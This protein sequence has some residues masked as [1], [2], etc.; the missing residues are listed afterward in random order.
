VLQLTKVHPA[1]TITVYLLRVNRA[2]SLPGP[3]FVLNSPPGGSQKMLR[4][5]LLAT[6]FMG[7]AKGIIPA[8]CVPAEWFP[9]TETF[10]AIADIQ[11]QGPAGSELHLEEQG[12]RVAATLRDY[13][14]KAIPVVTK[15]QGSIEE[16]NPVGGGPTTCK[17]RLSGKDNRGPVEVEGEITPVYFNGIITRRMG[18][19]V[20]S[21]RLSLKRQVSNQENKVG[22][23]RY[24]FGQMLQT[25]IHGHDREDRHRLSVPNGMD[26]PLRS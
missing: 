18:K 20:F 11:G 10:S 6:L 22:I 19:E 12:K 15:L 4:N 26:A 13:R 24:G 8:Q 5:L 9:K 17:V 14:G 16:S 2:L 23:L 25:T 1:F 3:G 21:Y 7:A